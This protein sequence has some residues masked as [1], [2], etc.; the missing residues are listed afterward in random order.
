[1]LETRLYDLL[2]LNLRRQFKVLT[3]VFFVAFFIIVILTSFVEKRYTSTLSVMPNQ[4]ESSM[5]SLG[6][7][8]QDFAIDAGSGNFPISEIANSN[9]ILDKIYNRSFDSNTNQ[10]K[11]SLADLLD[12]NKTTLINRIMVIITNKDLNNSAMLKYS[13]IKKFKE[14]RLNIKYDRKTNI[15]SIS[16][17]VEDPLAAKQIADSFYDE[18]SFFINKTINDSGKMKQNFLNQRIQSIESELVS[19]EKILEDFLNKNKSINQSPKLLQ[20][21]TRIQREVTLKETA[22][23]LLKKELEIARIDEVKRTLKLIIIEKPDIPAVKSYPSRL[24]LSLSIAFF[25]TI[26]LFFYRTIRD[27]KKTLEL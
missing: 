24:S 23:L 10:G 3:K 7:L 27:T 21:L 14:E 19:N 26:F 20:E 17:T 2:F 8:V 9:S 12:T 5:S 25:L 6:M 22:Y 13:T 15:T 16:V 11:I 1:M 18:I 4:S